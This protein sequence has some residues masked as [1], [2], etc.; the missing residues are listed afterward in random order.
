M[1]RL[2]HA[3]FALTFALAIPTGP[4]DAAQLLALHEAPV[5][6]PIL[7]FADAGG[8]TRSLADHRGKFVLLNIWA[9]W[10]VPCRTEM[11]TLDR[12]QGLLGGA[13]FEV[14]PVSIDRGGTE[15]VQKFFADTDIRNLTIN[16][17]ASGQAAFA[18]GILGL[19]GTLL[20]DRN[21]MEIGRLIG[22]TEWDAPEMVAL[23]K[24]VISGQISKSTR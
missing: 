24:S 23:L 2:A 9:T 1:R 8:T 18:L 19:P 13:D 16:V 15:V 4:A 5:P 3:I 12:L 20:L 22:P 6:V 14:L 10:C 17:D 11:P 21:G 7:T